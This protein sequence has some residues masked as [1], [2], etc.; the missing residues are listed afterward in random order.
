MSTTV[1]PR[2]RRKK[3]RYATVSLKATAVLEREEIGQ[4]ID[5]L[6]AP[7]AIVGELENLKSSFST[8]RGSHRKELRTQLAQAYDLAVFLRDDQGAWIDFCRL[9]EWRQVRNR[10]TEA[11]PTDP[12]GYVLRYAIGTVGRAAT[13]KVSKYRKALIGFFDAEVPQQ[14]IVS[15]I[16]DAGGLE[17]LARLN[18]KQLKPTATVLKELNTEPELIL[19]LQGKAV[20]EFLAA[21]PGRRIGFE[22]VR[23][24]LR[25]STLTGRLV[26]FKIRRP[27]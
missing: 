13:K 22:V 15:K 24:K 16:R 5:E 7:R 23:T 10:P 26:K 12:L 18:A 14:K 20:T 6:S 8:L 27:E 25:G 2:S 21:R 11:N 3:K 1:S 19:R 17:K 9:A 4:R